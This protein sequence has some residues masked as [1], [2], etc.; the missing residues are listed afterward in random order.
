MSMAWQT[1][2]FTA[3]EGS[4]ERVGSLCQVLEQ[5]VVAG[6]RGVSLKVLVLLV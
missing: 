6:E 2:G 4:A 5:A 3:L 1:A